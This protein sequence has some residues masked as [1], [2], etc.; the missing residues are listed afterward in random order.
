MKYKTVNNFIGEELIDGGG[1]KLD[2]HT[3]L[4][5]SVISQVILST[6]E[7]VDKAVQTAKVAFPAWSATPI[8]ERV[9]VFF[10]YKRLLE[11]NMDELTKLVQTHKQRL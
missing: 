9:Q 8:K 3:P 4:D 10:K 5:G 1:E 2:V 7:A 6:A 11:E